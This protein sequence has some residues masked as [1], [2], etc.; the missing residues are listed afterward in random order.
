[1]AG[2]LKY[3]KY[4]SDDGSPWA[5]LV[6]ESNVENVCTGNNDIAVVDVTTHPYWVPVFQSTTSV[7]VRKIPIPTVAEYNDLATAGNTITVR[8][9]ADADTAETFQLKSLV[10]ERI[11]PVVVDG[12]TGLNDGDAT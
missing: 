10:P 2:S 12:D 5:M 8:T 1:M 7:R 9:F 4:F 6:D 11:R 3:M